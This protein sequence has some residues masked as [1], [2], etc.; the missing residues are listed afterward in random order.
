MADF[1]AQ[2]PAVKPLMKLNR[3]SL[4]AK[5]RAAMPLSPSCRLAPGANRH[6]RSSADAFEYLPPR[7]FFAGVEGR[8]PSPTVTPAHL[9]IWRRG[10]LPTLTM[11]AGNA[12]KSCHDSEKKLKIVA[13]SSSSQDSVAGSGIERVYTVGTDWPDLAFPAS[14]IM[15]TDNH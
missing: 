5:L 11:V 2:S 9:A 7:N 10:T 15:K 4:P 13:E 8:S 1:A 6:A 14:N 3:L 12:G